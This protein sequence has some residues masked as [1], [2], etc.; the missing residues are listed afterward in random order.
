MNVKTKALAA[1]SAQPSF[2]RL[3]RL[4]RDLDDRSRQMLAQ[5]EAGA[6]TVEQAAAS[7]MSIACEAVCVKLVLQRAQGLWQEQDFSAEVVKRFAAEVVKQLLSK[8]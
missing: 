3:T 4:C 5:I 7:L 8:S 6:L 2:G 1:L